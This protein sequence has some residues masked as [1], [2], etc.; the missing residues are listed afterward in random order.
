LPFAR[1]RV[2][3]DAVLT[4]VL[5]KVRSVVVLTRVVVLRVEAFATRDVVRASIRR[6]SNPRAFTIPRDALRDANE[7]SG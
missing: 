4:A 6:A 3:V 1:E 2:A 7:R 5:P